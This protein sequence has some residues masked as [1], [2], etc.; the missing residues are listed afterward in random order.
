[1]KHGAAI[2]PPPIPELQRVA[3]KSQT[4]KRKAREADPRQTSRQAV[5]RAVKISR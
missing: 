2:A 4:E 5:I 1:M 3:E